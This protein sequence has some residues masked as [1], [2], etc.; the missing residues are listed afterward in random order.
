[1]PWPRLWGRDHD[2]ASVQ[3]EQR[4]RSC[5]APGRLHWRLRGQGHRGQGTHRAGRLLGASLHACSPGRSLPG[6][7]PLARGQ[8]EPTALGTGAAESAPSSL[9]GK[10]RPLAQCRA[11]IARGEQAPGVGGRWAEL[12]SVLGPVC[13]PCQGSR[14]GGSA[15]PGAETWGAGGGPALQ[16]TCTLAPGP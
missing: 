1:M 5:V 3:P 15:G 16:A 12:E 9:W 8:S 14:G 11:V 2:P 6:C 7:P 4:P 10:C 13:P